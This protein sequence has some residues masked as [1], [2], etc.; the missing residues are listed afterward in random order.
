MMKLES[1]NIMNETFY[2]TIARFYEAENQDFTDDLPLYEE[3]AEGKR[4]PILD[5]GC[6]TGRVNLYLAQAGY[7]TI[8]V[9]NSPEML[10]FARRKRDALQL[11]AQLVEADILSFR[12]G[13]YPLIL[14]PFNTLMHFHEQQIIVLKHLA[15]L[16]ADDGLMVID[17]PNAGELLATENDEAVRFERTFFE[18]ISGNTVMQQSVST[19]DRAEQILLVNWIYDEILPDKTVKRTVAPL[20]LRLISAPEIRLLMQ[21]SELDIVEL[22]GDYGR[23]PFM[24]GCERMIVVAR[25]LR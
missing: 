9:D 14:L 17:L 6:G 25:K 8:G 22:Y 20:K 21:L 2:D 15:G 4:G 5:V 11:D 7:H 13:R 24:D 1:R 3:F 18:P 10:A 23:G 19:I 12:D 16:L